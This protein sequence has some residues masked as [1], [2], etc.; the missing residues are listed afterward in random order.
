MKITKKDISRESRYCDTHRKYGRKLDNEKE[1]L[2]KKGFI[3]K[4]YKPNL[5][6]HF[7]CNLNNEP[8]VLLVSIEVL[9]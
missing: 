7:T 2:L 6:I 3:K 8:V 9:N 4:T 1:V 5:E